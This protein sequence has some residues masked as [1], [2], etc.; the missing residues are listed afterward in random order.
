MMRPLIALGA[1][2]VGVGAG[3]GAGASARAGAGAGADGVDDPSCVTPL[4]GLIAGEAPPSEVTSG[5][6]C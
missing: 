3:P 6:A 2:E 1:A 5:E 4:D